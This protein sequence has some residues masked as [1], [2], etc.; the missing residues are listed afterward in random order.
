MSTL[1]NFIVAA[2][3]IK[4]KHRSSNIIES[5]WNLPS[6]LRNSLKLDNLFNMNEYK[7]QLASLANRKV[8]ALAQNQLVHWQQQQRQQQQQQVSGRKASLSQVN[9]QPI[10]QEKLQRQLQAPNA[11][12]NRSNSGNGNATTRTKKIDVAESIVPAGQANVKA[13]DSAQ[14]VKL[15]QT[16]ELQASA[17]TIIQPAA[18]LSVVGNSSVSSS[19]SPGGSGNDDRDSM[20]SF[21]L[22]K[23]KPQLQQ[24]VVGQTS[25][26]VAAV[27]AAAAATTTPTSAA[28]TTTPKDLLVDQQKAPESWA[29][30]TTQ[31]PASLKSVAVSLLRADSVAKQKNDSNLIQIEKV[32][33]RKLAEKKQQLVGGDGGGQSLSTATLIDRNDQPAAA[34][35]KAENE[36][37]EVCLRQFLCRLAEKLNKNLKS[38]LASQAEAKNS[39]LAPDNLERLTKRYIR[40]LIGQIEAEQ[41]SVRLSSNWASKSRDESKGTKQQQ[42]RHSDWA[43]KNEE[44]EDIVDSLYRSAMQ[45]ECSSRYNCVE[46]IQLERTLARMK[47]R[48]N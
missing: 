5:Q 29:S 1:N 2:Q 35:A 9:L 44:E 39:T 15:N 41:P 21:K 30:V 36:Q 37:L 38:S 47:L 28:S 6:M 19:S 8:L 31:R 13:A 14:S 10:G 43:K 11:D 12:E 27:A 24:Q 34:P 18:S 22:V 33:A 3:N 20:S 32:A 4:R 42:Q 40:Q 17:S 26:V 7:R 23:P 48:F 16:T 45:N 46:L 25:G